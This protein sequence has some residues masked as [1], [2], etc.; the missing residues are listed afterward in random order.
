MKGGTEDKLRFRQT[1]MLVPVGPLCENSNKL[2]AIQLWRTTQWFQDRETHFRVINIYWRKLWVWRTWGIL[3]PV[4]SMEE[5]EP[6]R[7]EKRS[8]EEP[9]EN[10]LAKTK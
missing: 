10:S 6:V 1:E 8:K 4:G 9:Q 3:T 2:L 7:K 5:E